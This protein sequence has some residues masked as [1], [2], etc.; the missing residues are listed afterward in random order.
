MSFIAFRELLGTLPLD[1]VDFE[2]EGVTVEDLTVVYGVRMVG[3]AAASGELAERAHDG[4]TRSPIFGWWHVE[5]ADESMRKV[6]TWRTGA[7]LAKTTTAGVA[8]G[9]VKVQLLGGDGF[10]GSPDIIAGEF[11]I[12][13]D[14]KSFDVYLDPQGPDKVPIGTSV[15]VVRAQ[16]ENE[17]VLIGSLAGDAPLIAQWRG[18]FV[19]ISDASTKVFDI[20]DSG[21]AELEIDPDMWA[22]LGT[23][24]RITGAL[25]YPAPPPPPPPDPGGSVVVLPPP[26]PLPDAANSLAWVLADTA[27]GWADG[28]LTS[29]HGLCVGYRRYEPGG[30]PDRTLIAAMAA[31]T[32]NGVLSFGNG[33]SDKHIYGV[34]SDGLPLVP[35]HL[36]VYANW[37]RPPPHGS[38]ATEDGPFHIE[39][40]ASWG[41]DRGPLK[42]RVHCTFDTAIMGGRY[43]WW[44]LTEN[45][46]PMAGSP[47]HPAGTNL[48]WMYQGGT[49]W[50]PI[51]RWQDDL[52]RSIGESLPQIPA[53]NATKK[54][55]AAYKLE[56]A[57]VTA[58]NAALEREILR[59]AHDNPCTV[60][61]VAFGAE[62]SATEWRPTRA[63]YADRLPGGLVAGG[64]VTLPAG[65]KLTDVAADIDQPALAIVHPT[66]YDVLCRVGRSLANRLDLV[67][68]VPVDGWR[69][70]L[71]SSGDVTAAPYTLAGVA[72]PTRRWIYQGTLRTESAVQW[73]KEGYAGND[74]ID[75]ND[76]VLIWDTSGGACAANIPQATG[77]GR[78]LFFNNLSGGANL[79]ITPA[80]GNID[81]AA[82]AVL[83]TGAARGWIDFAADN[84][85]KITA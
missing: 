62:G 2:T 61:T 36:D 52:S 14:L 41:S 38:I 4:G 83:A 56:L 42:S 23:V 82:T 9:K 85:R 66:E 8:G 28:E 69:E 31:A 37:H 81:G 12:N 51:A 39:S 25:K 45:F 18:P 43:V 30:P 11:P 84:W 15:M 58:E 53:Q 76:H 13:P 1:H 57:R 7:A 6:G 27:D 5:T 77:S 74:T 79:T 68:G 60:H 40:P 46:Q 55:R 3:K 19:D 54:Q 34:T 29:G 73:E 33:A 72:A 49:T 80:A 22:N 75:S 26:A 21:S 63:G 64:R 78:V 70:T 59:R 16:L 20:S 47:E 24:W 32:G 35:M 50:Q 67:T 48:E 17:Q 65:W 71:D 44:V 10:E